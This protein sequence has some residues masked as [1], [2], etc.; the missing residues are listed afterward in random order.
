MNR[1]SFAR[2]VAKRSAFTLIELLVVIAI[3]AILAG[4]LLPALSKAKSKAVAVK[5]QN[6]VKQ[7]MLAI[8]LY[9]TEATD[10]LTEPNWNSPWL[11]RGWLYDALGGSVP[12][13]NAAP[14]NTNPELAY[15]GGVLY[16]YIKTVALY[17][18]PSER[19]NAIPSFNSRAQKMTSFLMNGAVCGYGAIAGRS[20]RTTQY[21]PNDII[22]WQAFEN[23]PGD[24]NDGSSSPAEGVTTMHNLGTTVGV[25][26][27]HVEY[28]KTV[29]F[30]TEQALPARN[31][32]FCS[33]NTANGR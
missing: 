2:T 33:P 7:F 11:A 12:N 26:D 27:G 21:Q 9:S 22:F 13:L 8:H 14:Y 18:C 6:N 20:Y 1:L 19:T 5:C 23:N 31:R 15:Q 3:I 28:I 17:R 4:M 16:P 24:W 30:Y 10:L 32:L 29:D 25:L